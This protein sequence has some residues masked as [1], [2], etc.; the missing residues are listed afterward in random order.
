VAEVLAHPVPQ[1][2]LALQVAQVQLVPQAQQEV[3]HPLLAPQ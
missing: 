1:V 2:A 3:R